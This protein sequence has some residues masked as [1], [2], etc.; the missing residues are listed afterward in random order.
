[1]LDTSHETHTLWH[2]PPTSGAQAKRTA[3]GQARWLFRDVFIRRF[4]LAARMMA[5]CDQPKAEGSSVHS[6]SMR[7]GVVI[8]AG[9]TCSTCS[10][11]DSHCKVHAQLCQLHKVSFFIPLKSCFC[12]SMDMCFRCCSDKPSVRPA[13]ASLA[14]PCATFDICCR[15]QAAQS[16]RQTPVPARP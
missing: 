8:L 3:W 11:R 2:A 6:L 9:C 5:A 13:L 16:P 15:R 7:K 12:T 10:Q 4:L 14:L 1:M